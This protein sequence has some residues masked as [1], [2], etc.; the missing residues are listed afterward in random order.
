M[1]KITEVRRAAGS[2]PCKESTSSEDAGQRTELVVA[3]VPQALTANI[4]IRV[5]RGVDFELPPLAKRCQPRQGAPRRETDM[6]EL[7][8][9]LVDKLKSADKAVVE[10]MAADEANVQLFLRQPAEALVAAGVELTRAD[11]KAIARA[12]QE[13]EQTRVVAPGVKVEKITATAYPRGKVGHIKP[14]ARPP[15]KRESNAGCAEEE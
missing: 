11:Q 13:V 5:V 10:W 6:L 3:E 9:D 15:G 14:G 2:S 8:A 1:Q 4:N 12:N 7:P